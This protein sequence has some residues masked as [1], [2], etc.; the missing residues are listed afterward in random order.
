MA[1]WAQGKFNP[2]NPHK[3]VGK[4]K[5]RFRSG[6]EFS[7]MHFLDNNENV[8]R[9]ASEAVQ[10]PYKNPFTGKSTVYVP[11]FFIEY[12]DKYGQKHVEIVEIKPKKQS[13][14]EGKMSQKDKM[15]VALNHAKWAAC[16]AWC[17]QNGLTFR[18]LTEHELFIN[19]APR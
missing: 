3:Y 12:K 15:V 14:I 17:N 8:L 7:F 6:W 18:I 10:I 1:N 13:V 9:W 4:H 19:G 16:K 5:P 11:D 2:K